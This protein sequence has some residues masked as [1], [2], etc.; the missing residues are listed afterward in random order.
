MFVETN[1]WFSECCDVEPMGEM[2]MSTVSYGGPSGFCSRCHDN[3][4]FFV[5][6]TGDPFDTV[7]EKRGER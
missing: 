1:I 3:C 2:D 6:D 4:I 7:E 5:E